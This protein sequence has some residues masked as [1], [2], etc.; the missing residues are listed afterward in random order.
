MNKIIEFAIFVIFMTFVL[1][2]IENTVESKRWA[3][4]LF[5]AFVYLYAGIEHAIIERKK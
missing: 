3:M 5:G 1:S 4:Q 2:L